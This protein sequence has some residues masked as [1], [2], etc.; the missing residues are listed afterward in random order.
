MQ[1]LA[2]VAL[3]YVRWW[4]P[5]KNPLSLRANTLDTLLQKCIIIMGVSVQG[6]FTEPKSA[7]L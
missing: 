5:V 6:G 4:K 1:L 7:A 2:A 3:Y